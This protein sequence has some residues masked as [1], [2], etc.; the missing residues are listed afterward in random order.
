MAPI[1]IPVYN[2]VPPHIIND[3]LVAPKLYSK[4]IYKLIQLNQ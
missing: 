2:L 4:Q 3:I 1:V